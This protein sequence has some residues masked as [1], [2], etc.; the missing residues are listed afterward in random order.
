VKIFQFFTTRPDTIYGVTFMVIAPEHPFLE[1]VKDQKVKDF[2][3]QIKAQSLIER[4][5]EEK[6]KEGID[7]GIKIINP[8]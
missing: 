5:S 8:F 7:T 3:R 2:I 1:R 6:E 4:L